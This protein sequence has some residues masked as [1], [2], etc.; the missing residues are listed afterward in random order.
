MFFK[1][2]YKKSCITLPEYYK[3]LSNDDIS[4]RL[5]KTI[6]PP[7]H[8]LENENS[9]NLEELRKTKNDRLSIKCIIEA[10]SRVFKNSF[11]YRT[12]H[13]WNRVP[14][15]IR[16]CETLTQFES[17]LKSYLWNRALYELEPD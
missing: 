4:T 10:N 16:S 5:R 14:V 1:I 2:Y 7:E 15:E 11:F 13:E 8:L 6:K 9:I 17:H 12:V 3:P